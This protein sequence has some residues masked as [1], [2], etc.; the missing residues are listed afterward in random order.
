MSYLLQPDCSNF[1]HRML[2]FSC[3]SSLFPRKLSA[4][5]ASSFTDLG[6]HGGPTWW[7]VQMKTNR[8]ISEATTMKTVR[9]GHMVYLELMHHDKSNITHLL[10]CKISAPSKML[11]HLH[12]SETADALK[13]E[14]LEQKYKKH[15]VQN[16]PRMDRRS[17]KNY[18]EGWNQENCEVSE[19]NQRES[20]QRRFIEES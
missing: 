7:H 2:V 5:A 17:R 11:V 3:G 16:W 13:L 4:T 12:I 10:G 18:Y 8:W 6:T 14:Q 19:G 9:Y 15:C 1:T 20:Y